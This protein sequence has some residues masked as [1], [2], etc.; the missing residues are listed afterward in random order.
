MVMEYG[1]YGDLK[2]F[3]DQNGKLSEKMASWFIR[4]LASAI[5]YMQHQGVIHRDIKAENILIGDGVMLSHF[6]LFSLN[7]NCVTLDGQFI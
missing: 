7:Q 2:K 4:R 1:L 6:I 5:A 3:L